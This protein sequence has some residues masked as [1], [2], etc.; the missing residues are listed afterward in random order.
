MS[1]EDIIVCCGKRSDVKDSRPGR[2]T[3]RRR[4]KCAVCGARWS[5]VEVALSDG[6]EQWQ[7]I[8]MA[9]NA[10][11]AAHV[12]LGALKRSFLRPETSSEPSQ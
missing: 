4:R 10:L 1:R 8:E 5:T 2:G 9:M 12:A 3:L 6:P 11:G 7:Q